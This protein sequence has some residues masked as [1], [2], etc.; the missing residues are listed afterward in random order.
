MNRSR[1]SGARIRETRS[2]K[3]EAGC[4]LEK[5]SSRRP[6]VGRGPDPPDSCILAPLSPQTA[7]QGPILDGFTEMLGGD[8]IGAGQVCNRACDFEDPIISSRA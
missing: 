3:H 5:D 2:A 6:E 8:L 4:F 7:I 1:E